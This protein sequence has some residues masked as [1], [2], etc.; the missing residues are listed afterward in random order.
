MILLAAWGGSFHKAVAERGASLN[1]EGGPGLARGP[2]GFP[3]PLSSPDLAV[4]RGGGAREHGWSRA[5][6][7][8][9]GRA[10][11]LFQGWGEV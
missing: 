7:R 2:R 8:R 1:R 5:S 3:G 11:L 10:R 6:L 9:W 4:G